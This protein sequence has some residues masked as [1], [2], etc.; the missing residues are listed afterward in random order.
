[1]SALRE[2]LGAESRRIRATMSAVN[3]MSAVGTIGTVGVTVDDVPAIAG[4]LAVL[5][6]HGHDLASLAGAAA[7]AA[8]EEHPL[9]A[10]EH[11]Q[12]AD[13]ALIQVTN[14]LEA[15]TYVLQQVECEL[16]AMGRCD[17]RSHTVRPMLSIL[18]SAGRRGTEGRHDA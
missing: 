3:T 4:Y 17:H 18:C 9:R 15:V 8:A 11:G 2:T 16:A 1:M 7:E 5:A 6:E 12:A 10:T 14:L 13:L